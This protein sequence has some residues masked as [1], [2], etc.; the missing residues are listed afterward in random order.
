TGNGN[1]DGKYSNPEY[2]ALIEKAR[3]IADKAEHYALLHEAENLALKD[4]AMIPVVSYNDFWLQSTKL[5]GTWHTPYGFWNF[6][7]IYIHFRIS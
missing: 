5:K 7:Y 3:N 6:M 1:N 2:D 4:S